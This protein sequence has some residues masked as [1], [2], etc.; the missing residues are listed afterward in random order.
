MNAD[1]LKQYIGLLGGL[2]SAILLFLGTLNVKFEWFNEASIGAFE[3]VLIA[4]APFALLIYGVYKNSYIV[5]KKAKR[6]EEEL[7]RK[8]LK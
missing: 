7:K 2:L 1:K 8:G 5:T 6:Q 4:V 3:G